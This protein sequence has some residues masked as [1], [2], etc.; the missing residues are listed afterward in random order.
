MHVLTARGVQPTDP[1]NP[2]ITGVRKFCNYVGRR[3]EKSVLLISA[4]ARRPVRSEQSM[5]E[6][7]PPQNFVNFIF[8]R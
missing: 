4:S 2:I 3:C 1:N 6:L 7:A 8:A 5:F